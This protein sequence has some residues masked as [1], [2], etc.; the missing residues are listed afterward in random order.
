MM[1]A[2]KSKMMLF[3]TDTNKKSK[4]CDLDFLAHHGGFEPSTPSVGGLCSI[5][6]S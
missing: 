6:L 4:S 2:L 5:Q 1:F 3:P